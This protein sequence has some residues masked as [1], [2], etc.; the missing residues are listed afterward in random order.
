MS[1]DFFAPPPFR[2]DEALLK[3][4][5]ELRALGLAERAGAFERR[6]QPVA[7][8]ALH[9]GALAAERV[10]APARSPQWE[11]HPIADHAALRDFVARLRADLAR[12][13]DRDE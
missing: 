12:W 5:K 8:A 7:R 6:G 11:R 4:R 13:G 1:D 3:L 10:R 2:P 9:D